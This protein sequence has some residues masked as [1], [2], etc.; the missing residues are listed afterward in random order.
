MGN[1]EEILLK[2]FATPNDSPNKNY[3]SVNCTFSRAIVKGDKVFNV[4]DNAYTIKYSKINPKYIQNLELDFKNRMSSIATLMNNISWNTGLKPTTSTKKKLRCA[5]VKN[6]I[7]AEFTFFYVWRRT[8][9]PPDD[10]DTSGAKHLFGNGYIG[11]K[12]LVKIKSLSENEWINVLDDPFSSLE[13][14]SQLVGFLLLTQSPKEGCFKV[15]SNPNLLDYFRFFKALFSIINPSQFSIRFDEKEYDEY[16]G[17]KEIIDKIPL[18]KTL[19]KAVIKPFRI[20]SRIE[21]YS[22]KKN[23]LAQ[24]PKSVFISESDKFDIKKL[25]GR[26]LVDN[27]SLYITYLSIYESNLSLAEYKEL[28]GYFDKHHLDTIEKIELIDNF[29]LEFNVIEIDKYYKECCK[30]FAKNYDIM[31]S[32]SFEASLISYLKGVEIM[33]FFSKK[34]WELNKIETKKDLE[35]FRQENYSLGKIIVD[36]SLTLIDEII[37]ESENPQLSTFSFIESAIPLSGKIN[38][39]GIAGVLVKSEF[40]SYLD[41]NQFISKYNPFLK[42]ELF[43]SSKSMKDA[44]KSTNKKIKELYQNTHTAFLNDLFDQIDDMS[45]L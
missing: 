3:N 40:T 32:Y 26:F 36:K 25:F 15:E 29:T 41:S 2:K 30:F 27:L 14:I 18:A 43:R 38:V 39:K 10:V 34:E 1:P 5:S 17:G 45:N 37:L 20:F 35:K 19:K 31:E 11:V 28:G 24:Q 7:L 16:L 44:F 9:Y 22:F 8:T 6:K 12:N 13:S 42:N 23:F 33:R 4:I 21:E